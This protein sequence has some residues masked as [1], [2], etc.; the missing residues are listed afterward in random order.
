MYNQAQEIQKTV[1]AL[2]R[3]AKLIQFLIRKKN[4]LG[5]EEVRLINRIE[6]EK[7]PEHM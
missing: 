4:Q 7:C 2:R 6:G 3:I 5:K 1:S